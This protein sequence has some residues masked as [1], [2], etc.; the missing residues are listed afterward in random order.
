MSFAQLSGMTP[1]QY[2]ENLVTET[3]RCGDFYERHALNKIFIKD[4]A[5]LL[6]LV[7]ENTEE[8][9]R[10]QTRMTLYFMPAPCLGCRDTTPR[11]R[12]KTRWQPSSK[13]NAEKN[14]P[15]TNHS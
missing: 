6:A 5:V 2:I 9:W 12:G 7:W 14:G 1:Y 13:H 3:L 10:K 11:P 4:L 15:S 8:A